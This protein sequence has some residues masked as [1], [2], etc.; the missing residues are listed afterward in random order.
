M[1]LLS[2]AKNKEFGIAAISHGADAVYIGADQF[3]AR[4]AA[5]N[6]VSE[7]EELV[8]Y[9]HLYNARVYIAL[10]TILFDHELEEAGKLI[11]D[12]WNAGAD[13]LIIQDMGL[14]E[15]DLP[16]IPLFASTQ[17]NNQTLSQVRFL[18]ASGFERVV[19]ARELGLREIE[20]ISQSTTIALE[21]FVHG[22]LCAC[23]SGQCYFS[24]AIG[25]RSANR[26]ECGQPCRLSWNLISQTGQVLERDRHLLSLKDMNRSDHIGRLARA[27]ITSFKIE[28]RL[29]DLA[30]VKN[31]TAFYREKLDAFMA[32]EVNYTP[33]SSGRTLFF[34]KPD[35]LK[36]FNRGETDYFLFGR[37]GKVHSF[38]TPKSLGE[39]I[40]VVDRIES[41]YMTLKKA[42]DINNGD[43]LCYLDQ[44]GKLQGFQVNSTDRGKI[45]PSGRLNLIKSSLFSKALIYRNHDHQFLKKLAGVS[46]ERR[47]GI[48]LSFHET[49]E[50]FVLKGRDEDE[51]LSE[52]RFDMEKIPAQNESAGLAT[53][54]K[55]LGKLGTSI[56]YLKGLVIHSKPYFIPIR[57]LNKMRRGLLNIM[58]TKRVEVYRRFDAIPRPLPVQ[59]P[60][61]QVDFTG[62]VSNE[63]AVQFYRKRGVAVIDPG[64]ELSSPG[65]GT[66]VM[67][68]RHCIRQALGQCPKETK[69]CLGIWSDPLFLENTKGRFQIVFDCKLCRMKIKIL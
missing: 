41:S 68:L 59:Y 42:H 5:G 35:P 51:N 38:D 60:E 28:G 39:K 58:T 53:L 63:K 24:A 30:Y 10:N 50:G 8:S 18:E 66:V 4:T 11:E 25:K 7:I 22:A 12:L 67:T 54:K 55:Q 6:Q 33:V 40:G 31:I 23:Y 46:A 2:P 52:F 21:A 13:A 65:A 57:D 20:Q 61:S 1:E 62:N 69:N 47:I 44:G 14:L 26:G 49:L 64:F 43:G 48:E 36:T 9:A 19:F 37:K 56:F 29:K 17:V 32:N 3:S 34:F 45:Y 16:P 15:M 27:G